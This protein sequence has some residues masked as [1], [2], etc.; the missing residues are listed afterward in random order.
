MRVVL[1]LMF[2]VGLA[3]AVING[4]R[5]LL[6]ATAGHYG[7]SLVHLVLVAFCLRGVW[8]SVDQHIRGPR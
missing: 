8:F 7:D 4:A 5:V 3:A 1:F 2:A 6:Y